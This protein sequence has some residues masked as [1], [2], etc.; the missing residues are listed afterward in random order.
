MDFEGLF[1]KIM[2]YFSMH[3]KTIQEYSIYANVRPHI[4]IY[5]FG[6]ILC[7][8]RYGSTETMIWNAHSSQ[9]MISK[10]HHLNIQAV[11]IPFFFLGQ[12]PREISTQLNVT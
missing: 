3:L 11:C 4:Y 12:G 10:L 8:I 6:F 9:N 2:I 1:M 5:I 7:Y